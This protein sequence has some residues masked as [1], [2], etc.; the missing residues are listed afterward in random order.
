MY[1]IISCMLLAVLL[2][3]ACHNKQQETTAP[4]LQADAIKVAILLYPDVELLDFAGPSEVFGNAKGF[5]V[6]TVS[7]GDQHIKTKNSTLQIDPAYTIQDAPQP[8]I[9]VI[10]GAST[11]TLEPL[12]NNPRLIDWIKKTNEK[13][14][15]TMSVCTGAELLSKAGLLDNKSATTHSGAVDMLQQRTPKA[16]FVKEVRWVE[17]GKIITTAGIS[18]GI[19]GALHVVSKLKGLRE[20]LLVTGIL[21]YD[22]WNEEAGLVVGQQNSPQ[23][24]TMKMGHIDM[25]HQPAANAIELPADTKDPVCG[26]T[27]KKGMKVNYSAVAGNTTHYFCSETCKK[28]FMKHVQVYT[29]E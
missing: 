23:E 19:D 29:K 11:K 8:D 1:K 26:I 4:P 16:K 6:Y 9:L 27:L 5:Q 3:P 12:L 14:G 20:A 22:K 18:A 28:T 21:E 7:T 25:T 10:P 24:G 17:D 2:L 15:L 13:T